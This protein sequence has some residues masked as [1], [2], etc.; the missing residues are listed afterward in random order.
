MSDVINLDTIYDLIN[1]TSGLLEKMVCEDPKLDL[2]T[3]F[4]IEGRVDSP[5]VARKW[6]DIINIGEVEVK[7]RLG[8]A[9]WNYQTN[10]THY[11]AEVK[12]HVNDVTG[13]LSSQLSTQADLIAV[14]N[15]GVDFTT[16]RLYK[17]YRAG[18]VEF[19]TNAQLREYSM[20]RG[21]MQSIYSRGKVCRHHHTRKGMISRPSCLF[22]EPGLQHIM[23]TS[24]NEKELLWAWRGW[25]DAVGHPMRALYTKYVDLSNIAAKGGGFPDA[26]AVWIDRY[27]D[28]VFEQ[29]VDFLWKSVEP[30]YRQLHTYVRRKLFD[31]YG[32]TVVDLQGPIPAHLLGNMWA[33]EWNNIYDLVEPYPDHG[34][35]DVTVKMKELQWT[36]HDMFKAA[37][38]FFTSLG[39]DPMPPSFWTKSMVTRPPDRRVICHGAAMDMVKERDVRIKMCTE[40]TMEDLLTVHHEMGH[41]QYFLQYAKQH[42]VFRSGANPAF[43][44]AIGDTIAL[45][46]ATPSYFHRLGLLSEPHYD[47]ES[48]INFLMEKALFKIAFLPF[49][50]LIDKWRW[51]VFR[52]EVEPQ[53]Y[54]SAWWEMR[55]RYQGVKSPLPRQQDDFDPGAKFHVASGTPYIRYFI[56]YIVQFQFH[57]ALCNAAGYEGPLHL[58]NIYDS[59]EAGQKLRSMLSLGSSLP[60]QDALERLTGQRTVDTSAMEEYF[61]PLVQWLTRQNRGQTVGW[62]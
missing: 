3:H 28:P 50:L 40:V 19:S 34:T 29:E 45:S 14:E 38:R 2:C 43:H 33:Q 16:R 54:N 36:V 58:C 57:K 1:T 59:K 61:S 18:R 15:I 26:A 48:T 35:A 4:L 11:N 41:C 21:L 37:N 62:D 44:E 9:M 23:A 22:L 13:I 49:G 5:E 20:V 31:V 47:Y 39:L 12:A 30:I 51:K 56:S 52:G 8:L 25:H 60:W 46:A 53:D 27:E 7:N 17:L 32:P 55:Q 24:R 6:M 42:I 10:M